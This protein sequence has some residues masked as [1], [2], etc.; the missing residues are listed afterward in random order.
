MVGEKTSSK[1][2]AR[3][4]T[5]HHVIPVPVFFSWLLGWMVGITL[6]RRKLLGIL[7]VRQWHQEQSGFWDGGARA[8]DSGGG[9]PRV[10]EGGASQSQPTPRM[11]TDGQGDAKVPLAAVIRCYVTLATGSRRA[12]GFIQDIPTACTQKTQSSQQELR[13]LKRQLHDPQRFL[14]L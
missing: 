13:S 14:T 5:D 11:V 1:P 3:V 4:L 7:R 6:P 10:E 9:H 2:A 12:E 8:V